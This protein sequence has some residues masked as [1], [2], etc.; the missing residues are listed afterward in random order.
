MGGLAAAGAGRHRRGARPLH[1]H[2]RSSGGLAERRHARPGRAVDADCNTPSVRKFGSFVLSVLGA[3]L[4]LTV[5]VAGF[6]VL[7]ID[8]FG[9]AALPDDYDSEI[10]LLAASTVLLAYFAVNASARQASAEA[11]SLRGDV[12]DLLARVESGLDTVRQVPPAEIRQRLTSNVAGASSFYFRGGSGRWLRSFTLPQLGSIVDREIEV[13]VQLLD[14]RDGELCEEYARYRAASRP[15]R[16]V[17][18]DERDPRLIQRDL[19]GSIYAAAWYSARTRMRAEVVLLRTFSPLRYD[20]SSEGLMITVADEAAAGLL[21]VAESWFHKA[22]VDEMRQARHGH[23]V[24]AL[25]A[26][27]ANFPPDLTQ[28]TGQQVQAALAAVTVEA[29]GGAPAPLLAGFAASDIEWE[30]VAANHVR[31]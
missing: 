8:L 3:L 1:G 6:A 7:A 17:R 24:A 13:S 14:P 4:P 11:S 29:A 31:T 20:V 28:V 27:G 9:L 5:G 22:V 23:A 16:A 19:L 30:L 12:R 21:A 18:D 26:A 25:P 2:S 10:L 15:A